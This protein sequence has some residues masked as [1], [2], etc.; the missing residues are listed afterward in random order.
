MGARPA[1]GVTRGGFSGDL[2]A[3]LAAA[4]PQQAPVSRVGVRSTRI[5]SREAGVPADA[6]SAPRRGAAQRRCRDA[7]A[8][9]ALRKPPEPGAADRQGPAPLA[10]AR[11]ADYTLQRHSR[12]RDRLLPGAPPRML[13]LSMPARRR[14]QLLSPARSTRHTTCCF[15]QSTRTYTHRTQH[16][17][18]QSTSLIFPTTPTASTRA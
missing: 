8:R 10:V 2:A 5:C 6:R 16:T 1:E 13:L 3:D 17:L 4:G 11:A 12:L 14:Q 15:T 18:E 9:A 7:R